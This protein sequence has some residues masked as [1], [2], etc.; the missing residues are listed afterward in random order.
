MQTCGYCS[1]QFDKLGQ[2]EQHLLAVHGV[3]SNPKEEFSGEQVNTELKSEAIDSQLRNREGGIP[4]AVL[5]G[6]GISSGG[7]RPS[8][9]PKQTNKQW[10]F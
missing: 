5:A 6:L 1:S 10:H 3:H 8:S 4:W 7:A 9:V 2:L